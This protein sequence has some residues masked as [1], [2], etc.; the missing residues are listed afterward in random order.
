MLLLRAVSRRAVAAFSSTSLSSIPITPRK[1]IS[2]LGVSNS[3][4]GFSTMSESSIKYPTEMSEAERYLFD[5]N[6]Y[7]IIRN[8]LSLE[9][10]AECNSAID[11]HTNEAVARS[12]D[13]L[14]N[15][16]KGSPMYGSGPPRLDLGG[17]FEWGEI[18]SRVFK[19]ILAHPRL[20][21][22]FHELLGKGYRLDHL[23]F[24]LM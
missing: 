9:E 23:P 10:V 2:Q 20:I 14:R 11:K 22:L 12:D 21:P 16:I 1:S 24:V 3:I 7:L 8:V 17:I 13:S 18:E 6:G 5:L 19:S 4:S 15:A